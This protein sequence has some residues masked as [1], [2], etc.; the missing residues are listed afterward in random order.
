MSGSG[1]GSSHYPHHSPYPNGDYPHGSP[2]PD[3][4]Y[5]PPSEADCLDLDPTTLQ[6]KCADPDD[7]IRTTCPCFC[8]AMSH[9]G[10]G[11]GSGSLRRRAATTPPAAAPLV[12]CSV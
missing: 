9:A 6:S 10:A 2:G 1:Y 11:Y 4:I 12:G 8:G 5:C 7:D 3:T